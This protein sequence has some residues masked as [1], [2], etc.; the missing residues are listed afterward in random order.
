MAKKIEKVRC[1]ICEVE[2]DLGAEH[3]EAGDRFECGWCHGVTQVVEVWEEFASTRRFT[4]ADGELSF[5]GVCWSGYADEK[6][7]MQRTAWR[8][9][10]EW[11]L[12]QAWRAS[13]CIE[14]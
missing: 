12:T 4:V 10:R 9:A 13:G 8:T 2:N 14:A 7:V 5:R 1:C 6:H 3:V 11:W